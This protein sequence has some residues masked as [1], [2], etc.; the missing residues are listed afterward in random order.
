[1]DL[2]VI[3]KA[4]LLKISCPS[5]SY[6]TYCLDITSSHLIPSPISVEWKE[7]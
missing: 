4:V 3:Q 5:L 2:S 7:V 6:K 1:M